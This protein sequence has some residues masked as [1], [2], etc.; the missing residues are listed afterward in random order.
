MKTSPAVA[1]APPIHVL[2]SGTG[3]ADQRKDNVVTRIS[4]CE[5]VPVVGRHGASLREHAF[6]TIV[7]VRDS[8]LIT[9]S[10]RGTDVN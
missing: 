5:N 10:Q 8:K 9:H 4:D 3:A 7:M 2:G 1:S 6:E